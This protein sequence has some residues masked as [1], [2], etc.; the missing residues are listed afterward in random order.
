MRM[1]AAPRSQTIRPTLE[2]LLDEQVD[3]LDSVMAEVRLGIRNQRH[4]DDL[5]ERA[6]AIGAEIRGAFREGRRA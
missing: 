1:A 6:G 4:Y 2:Q 3:A 5:E